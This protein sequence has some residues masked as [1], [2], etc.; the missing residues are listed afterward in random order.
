MWKKDNNKTMR[1]PMMKKTV[2]INFSSLLVCIVFCFLFG[3]ALL[4]P[5]NL[6][7]CH[8]DG[9]GFFVLMLCFVEDIV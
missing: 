2:S 6:L 1:H 8:G 3:N 7:L 4:V 9:N 5:D